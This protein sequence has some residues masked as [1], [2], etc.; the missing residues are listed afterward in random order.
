MML[1]EQRPQGGVGGRDGGDKRL[2]AGQFAF[3]LLA[4]E[5]HFM[6]LVGDD[7]VMEFGVFDG[8]GGG[9]AAPSPGTD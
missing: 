3:D 6:D 4:L 1:A 5:G 2:A 8:R 7:L 9:M